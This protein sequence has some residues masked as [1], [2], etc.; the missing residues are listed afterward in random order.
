LTST[1]T[2]SDIAK[3]SRLHGEGK[4]AS[5]IAA[6]L[7]GGV[8][9]NAVLG[10]IW[11]LRRSKMR[12]VIKAA[13]PAP[14]KPVVRKPAPAAPASP[15]AH[16]AQAPPVVVSGTPALPPSPEPRSGISMDELTSLACR[17]PLWSAR[18]TSGL[19]CGCRVLTAKSY[20]AEHLAIGTAHLPQRR[21]A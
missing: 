6:A 18:E 21:R 16:V 7:G 3:L 10:K 13:T 1:W 2:E 20:C 11:R 17:W 8:T 15:A 14:R 5:E 9:M 12:D 19:Y 4:S